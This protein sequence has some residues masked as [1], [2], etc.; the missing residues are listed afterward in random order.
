VVDQL[1]MLLF[2]TLSLHVPFRGLLG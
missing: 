1:V 2:E